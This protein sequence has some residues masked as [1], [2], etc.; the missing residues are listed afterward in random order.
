MGENESE[1][2]FYASTETDCMFLV[3]LGLQFVA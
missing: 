3:A 1:N 2:E